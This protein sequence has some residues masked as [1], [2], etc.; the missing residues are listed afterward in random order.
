MFGFYQNT[1]GAYQPLV[2]AKYFDAEGKSALA[3]DPAWQRLLRWQKS[4]VDYYGHAKLVKWQTGAGD[5]WSSPHAFGREKL[6]MMIDGEW[7]VAF[8]AADHKSV[9]YGTAPMPVDPSKKSLYGAGYINGTII[10]IPRNGDNREEA[11]KLV[12]Y[13][14]TNTHALA[15]FSNGIRNVPSTAA[16]ARSKELK[17]DANF[18]TFT[19]IFTHPRSGTIPITPLGSAHLETFTSFLAKW[20]AG[21]VKDLRS[22]LAEVD[23]QIDAKMKQ[24][25]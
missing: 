16:A 7:R 3:K 4:L 23:K 13:L 12:K 10:G 2:G 5:E 8:L 1:I 25:G 6:A 15:K 22:G 24:A 17:P 19:K 20:Q 11:W 18:A 9:Q 21:K 14:T